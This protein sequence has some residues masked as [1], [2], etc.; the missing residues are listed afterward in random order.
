MP[1]RLVLPG[2]K[3]RDKEKKN[4]HRVVGGVRAEENE[5]RGDTT[6]SLPSRGEKKKVKAQEMAALHL[7]SAFLK[8]N[9]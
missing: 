1:G 2:S 5:C 3:S 7:K 8:S 4:P 9:R 6:K